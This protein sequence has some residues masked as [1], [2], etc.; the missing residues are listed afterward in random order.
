MINQR[1]SHSLFIKVARMRNK[2]IPQTL[3]LEKEKAHIIRSENSRETE[4]LICCNKK[5]LSPA[6]AEILV[7]KWICLAR[8]DILDALSKI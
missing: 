8:D 1:V 5:N 2:K 4:L 3:H 6:W 7:Q